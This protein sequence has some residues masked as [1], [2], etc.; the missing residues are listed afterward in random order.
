MD[1]SEFEIV[2]IAAIAE[3]KTFAPDG[4]RPTKP[5]TAN[6]HYGRA[7]QHHPPVAPIVDLI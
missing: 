6:S 2:R 4:A 3:S 7:R 1:S 5:I